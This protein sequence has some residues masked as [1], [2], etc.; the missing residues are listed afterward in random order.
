MHAE[1]YDFGI[2]A[3]RPRILADHVLVNRT[4]V[5]MLV[6]RTCAVVFSRDGRGSR[7][8]QYHPAPRRVSRPPDIPLSAFAP[9]GEREQTGACRACP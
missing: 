7:P 9:S 3:R 5:K 6:E 2:D 4:G 1:P 8:G